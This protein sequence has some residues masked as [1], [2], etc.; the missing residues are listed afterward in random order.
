MKN[1]RLL[2]IFG[3]RNFELAEMSHPVKAA[4]PAQLAP[5][6]GLFRRDKRLCRADLTRSPD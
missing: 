1:L 5:F 4:R 6:K 2:S 3:V